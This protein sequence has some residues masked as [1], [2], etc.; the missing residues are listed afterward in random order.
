MQGVTRRERFQRF[1]RLERVP[2]SRD[3]FG[4]VTTQSPST[5]NRTQEVASSILVS[6]TTFSASGSRVCVPRDVTA[7]TDQASAPSPQGERIP[8]RSHGTEPTQVGIP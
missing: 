1:Q 8:P 5:L 6:S 7:D 2:E 4:N 3:S